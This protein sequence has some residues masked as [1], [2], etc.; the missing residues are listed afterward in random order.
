MCGF[1]FVLV[2][3]V[4]VCIEK[5]K[6]VCNHS[7]KPKNKRTGRV[8]KKKK[9]EKTSFELERL[10]IKRKKERKKTI[11]KSRCLGL[12]CLSLV[13]SG[14]EWQR[15]NRNAEASWRLGI[16]EYQSL[17]RE[18]PP[19]STVPLQGIQGGAELRYSLHHA[20]CL[21]HRAHGSLWSC[22]FSL[23]SFST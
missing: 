8:V 6:L 11:T 23:R 16:S 4:Y 17:A 12:C 9:S 22:T 2:L 1:A 5:V 18:M 3:F 20:H 19:T 7:V 10:T 15:V 14:P 13:S 21:S